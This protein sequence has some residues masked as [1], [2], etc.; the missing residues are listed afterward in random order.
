MPPSML[1]T[2]RFD[3]PVLLLVA[4]HDGHDTEVGRPLFQN[5]TLSQREIDHESAERRVIHET[6]AN[7]L[8]PICRHRER[9]SESRI[10]FVQPVLVSFEQSQLDGRNAVQS[11]LATTID[12]SLG[13]VGLLTPR[14]LSC[15]QVVLHIW[16]TRFRA[17]VRW[18]RKIGNRIFR[19]GLRFLKVVASSK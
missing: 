12:I 7:L 2:T 15:K 3:S 6:V 8:E 18:S 4:R 1:A 11:V 19:Y 13:G 14:A 5:G 16:D 10:L 17:E 9:R